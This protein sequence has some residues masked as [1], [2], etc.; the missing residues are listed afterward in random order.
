MHG[1]ELSPDF[2]TLMQVSVGLGEQTTFLFWVSFLKPKEKDCFAWE[3]KII[4]LLH[5]IG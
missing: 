1:K 5:W 3:V 4:A 2:H